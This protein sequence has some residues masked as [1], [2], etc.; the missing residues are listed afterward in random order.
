M[1]IKVC[2]EP[3]Y[4]GYTKTR[5]YR[6]HTKVSPKKDLRNKDATHEFPDTVYEFSGN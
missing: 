2:F 1:H 4:I 6:L 5:G 3:L